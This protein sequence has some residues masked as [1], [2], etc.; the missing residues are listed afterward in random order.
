MN[1]NKIWD[2]WWNKDFL[3]LLEKRLELKKCSILVDVG[4]GLGYMSFKLAPYLD[5]NARIIGFDKEKKYIEKADKIKKKVSLKN[6]VEFDF[7]VGNSNQLDLNNNFSDITIC[8]SLLLHTKDPLKTI[9]EMKRIT[10]KDGYI[11]AIEPNIEKNMYFINHIFDNLQTNKIDIYEIMMRIKKGKKKNHSVFGDLVPKLFYDLGLIEINIWLSDKVLAIIPPYNS[12]ETKYRVKEL[13]DIIEN[14]KG[15]FDYE[16]QL[17]YFLDGGGIKKQFDKYW[18]EVEKEKIK[19]VSNLENENFIG[20]E[21]TIM[22]IV[23]GKKSD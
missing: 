23:V 13:L 5:N 7:K 20:L 3:D 1:N 11:V 6:E 10:K 22:Y 12:I 8:R 16:K 18:M 2:Y 21:K 14:E 4:C 9:K 15:F 17:K 19:I